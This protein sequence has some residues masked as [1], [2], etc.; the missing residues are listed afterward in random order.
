MNSPLKWRVVTSTN[1]LRAYAVAI[2]DFESVTNTRID[3]ADM[4]TIKQWHDSLIGRRLSQNTIRARLSYVRMASGIK[5]PLPKKQK[6]A[7][8]L[9]SLKDVRAVL[10]Q[11]RTSGERQALM[12]SLSGFDAFRKH[13]HATRTDF[14]VHFLGISGTPTSAQALTRLLKRCAR[15]AGIEQSVNLRIW[16]RSGAWLLKVLSPKEF[17]FL[18]PQVETLLENAKPLHGINRRSHSVK[19]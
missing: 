8:D 9:L 3:Q 17:S 5:Y 15:T 14:D 19:A 6:T 18:M 12:S 10:A 13:A 16:V 11:A 4:L 1:T 7:A 2:K